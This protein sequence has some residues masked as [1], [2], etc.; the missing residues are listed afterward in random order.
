MEAN[1]SWYSS[2][3]R[4]INVVTRV[5]TRLLLSFLYGVD[6]ADGKLNRG[7]F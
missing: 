1:S 2:F 7:G 3:A 4:W 5:T 6:E